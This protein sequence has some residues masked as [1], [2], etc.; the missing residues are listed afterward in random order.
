MIY[1]KLETRYKKQEGEAPVSSFRGTA[2]LVSLFV[3]GVW[4]MSVLS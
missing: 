3:V 2:A 1:K 4:P